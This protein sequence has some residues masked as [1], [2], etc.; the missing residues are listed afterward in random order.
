MKELS[1]K[2]AIFAVFCMVILASC[3]QTGGITDFVDDKKV[4]DYVNEIDNV[5]YID[6]LTGDNLK[7]RDKRIEGLNP[8]KYYMIEKEVDT[9]GE[10]VPTFGRYDPYPVYATDIQPSGPGGLYYDLGYITKIRRGTIF[11]LPNNHN[12]YT[13]RAAGVFPFG[14]SFTYSEGNNSKSISVDSG[15]A[16]LINTTS[17][18]ELKLTLSLEFNNYQVTAVVA[19]SKTTNWNNVN[20]ENGSMD[21]SNTKNEIKLESI[22]ST[23][24]YVFVRKNDPSDFKFLKVMIRSL[25]TTPPTTDT[26][27]NIA[28]INGVTAPVTGA[29]PV[30][31]ITECNQYT[32]TVTWNGNPTTFAADTTYTATITLTPKTG[33]ILNGVAANFFT[34]ASTTSTSNSANSGV[35]TAVFPATGAANDETLKLTIDWSKPEPTLSPT[36]GNFTQA[37]YYNGILQTVEI[38][39]DASSIP[40]GYDVVKWLHDGG[41]DFSSFDT[42]PKLT[43]NNKPE[44]INCLSKGKHIITVVLKDKKTN[45]YYSLDFTLTVY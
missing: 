39:I 6:D 9:K 20:G 36:S 2:S 13:V 34:V 23:V 30:S 3:V 26:T 5:V 24:D 41:A 28:A 19:P 15:G 17:T 12:T 14:K 38:E 43:L 8:N 45:K 18:D 7:G 44:N 33:Y 4:Q 10:K 42:S 29:T 16:I 21:I 1:P 27:I 22:G 31:T 25:T 11:D 40:N 32:G 37:D 35:I